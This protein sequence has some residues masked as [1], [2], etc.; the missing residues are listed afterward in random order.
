MSP[1]KEPNP[2]EE[3]KIKYTKEYNLETLNSQ[4][5]ALKKG[6]GFLAASST[7]QIPASF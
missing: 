3:C 7:F 1:K 6:L 5:V 2:Y 4:L